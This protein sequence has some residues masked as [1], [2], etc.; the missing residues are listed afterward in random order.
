MKETLLK[1]EW[2]TSQ[3]TFERAIGGGVNNGKSVT[4]T[5]QA[6]KTNDI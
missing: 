6:M 4:E 2:L 1:P 5:L 3:G